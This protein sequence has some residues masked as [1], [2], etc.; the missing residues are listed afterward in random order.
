VI[1]LRASEKQDR[2]V[3][4]L[5]PRELWHLELK[6]D[7]LVFKSHVNLN[8]AL[9]LGPVGTVRAV[10]GYRVRAVLGVDV[11]FHVSHIGS[12][13]GASQTN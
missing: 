7:Y 13:V 2:K 10:E 1:F 4:K 5:L 11:I 6:L 9:V 3:I 12:V 8:A